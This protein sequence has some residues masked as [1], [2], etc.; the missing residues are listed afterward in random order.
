MFV[1]RVLIVSVLFVVFTLS[2]TQKEIDYIISKAETLHANHRS[3]EAIEKLRDLVEDIDDTK[4]KSIICTNIGSLYID[5]SNLKEAINWL[6]KAIK[7]N[8]SNS[9]AH[10]NLA[11]AFEMV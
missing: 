5:I 10:N 9:Q 8:P 1:H 6:E 7:L 11:I 4:L 3:M 2:A